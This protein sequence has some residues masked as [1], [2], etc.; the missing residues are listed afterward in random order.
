LAGT[1]TAIT[2]FQTFHYSRFRTAAMWLTAAV[3]VLE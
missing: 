3:I 1:A 2:I